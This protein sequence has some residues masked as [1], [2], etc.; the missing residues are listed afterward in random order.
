MIKI[1]KK[2]VP[3]AVDVNTKTYATFD[4]LEIVEGWECNVEKSLPTEL[5]G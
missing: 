3:I 4:L 5:S 1:K 2:W